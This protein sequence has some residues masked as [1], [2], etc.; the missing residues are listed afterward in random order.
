MRLN[1]FTRSHSRY[2]KHVCVQFSQ[3]LRWVSKFALP[4]SLALSTCGESGDKGSTSGGR[5]TPGRLE[6]AERE[7]GVG[8]GRQIKSQN[9]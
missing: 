1:V 3:T 6:R 2:G 4:D 5:Y 7:R 9:H 8:V